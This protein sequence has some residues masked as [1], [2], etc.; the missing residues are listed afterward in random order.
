MIWTCTGLQGKTGSTELTRTS[1]SLRIELITWTKS[2]V[3]RKNCY[4]YGGKEYDGMTDVTGYGRVEH[5]IMG[6]GKVE[7][8]KDK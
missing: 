8:K 6:N 7:M 4:K 5:M 1:K 3:V 2:E